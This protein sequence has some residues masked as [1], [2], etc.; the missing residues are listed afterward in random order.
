MR[1][2]RILGLGLAGVLSAAAL[3]GCPGTLKDKE[4]FLVDG[5]GGGA[6]PCPDVPAEILAG[7]CGG[8]GCHGGTVPAQGLDLES[9]GVAARVVG[10]PAMECTG[11]LADPQD[12]TGSVIY[13]K[14]G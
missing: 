4:R 10:K 12:P 6:A 14:L 9:P 5:G 13:T 8:N 11:I 1:I 3:A 7:K 2:E